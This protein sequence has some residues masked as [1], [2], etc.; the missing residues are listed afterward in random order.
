M[1]NNSACEFLKALQVTQMI[2]NPLHKPLG[3]VYNMTDHEPQNTRFLTLYLVP[4]PS[5]VMTTA[6]DNLYLQSFQQIHKNTHNPLVVRQ[7]FF[8]ITQC[9]G[10]QGQPP[11]A[12]LGRGHQCGGSLLHSLRQGR[13]GHR[14]E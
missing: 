14:E 5:E 8:I 11:S 9:L 6:P 2:R 3:S 1:L 12:P 4:T 10:L 13:R 7:Q